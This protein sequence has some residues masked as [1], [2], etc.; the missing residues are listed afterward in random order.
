[1]LATGSPLGPRNGGEAGR[2][3]ASGRRDA[4]RCSSMICLHA[5]EHRARIK[6]RQAAAARSSLS[7][8]GARRRFVW[9][10]G[11]RRILFKHLETI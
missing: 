3:G 6:S 7:L 9:R 10:S 5:H 8:A 2:T 1:M 11:G 4:A